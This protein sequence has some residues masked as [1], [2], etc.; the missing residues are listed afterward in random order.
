[1]HEVGA[2]KAELDVSRE[3]MDR[4]EAL[5][6]QTVRWNRKINLISKESVTQI[7][8]RHIK[9]SL[10]IGRLAS[11]GS[12]WADLGSGGG[13]PALVVASE[14]AE[15]HPE[16]QF[17]LVESDQRKC[18][19]L[20]TAIQSLSLNAKVISQRIESVPPIGANIISARA[21][22]PLN[23]L[24]AYADR[25]LAHDGVC[26][27]PKGQ[28]HEAELSESLESWTYQSEIHPSLTNPNAAILKLW[29]IRRV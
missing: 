19:F 8:D 18:A 23:S 28:N 2:L 22:A 20:R 11:S 17:V 10:Q 3:T 21:L 27:F 6:D 1:M 5:V 16:T 26:L 9:D 12:L 24:L 29:N 4:L 14:W 15:L 25:H 13:F 7:W